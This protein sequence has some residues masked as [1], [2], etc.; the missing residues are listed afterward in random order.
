MSGRLRLARLVPWSIAG[1]AG[2]LVLSGCGLGQLQLTAAADTAARSLA[3]IG[4]T[5]LLTDSSGKVLP[6]TPVVVT[7]SDGRLTRVA[8]SGP[9]GAVV[10]TMATD[11]ASWTSDTTSLSYGS[12]YKISATAVDRTGLATNF[13]KT[14]ATVNPSNF[15]RATV[16]PFDGAIVGVGYPATITLSRSI[17]AANKA[18]ILKHIKVTINGVTGNGAWRWKSNQVIEYR[19]PTYFPGN[20]TISVGINLRG[21]EVGGGAYGLTDSTTTYH[22]GDSMI[23]Y[24]NIKTHQMT[25]T[26]NG[27]TIRVIPVTMGKP[28]FDTRSGVKVILTKEAKRFM[29][30]ATGGTEK[31][32]PNYYAL[33]VLDAMRLTWSG[34]FLHGAPWSVAAQGVA[35]VSHGC[36]GM[37]AA[38]AAWLFSQSRIGDVVV[39]TGSARPMTLDNG[40]GVWNL[41]WAQWQSTSGVGTLG[42]NTGTDGG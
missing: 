33:W 29:D 21:V 37:S 13:T 20:S 23:S 15:V 32:S 34:E 17:D 10:G 28:G 30:A 39:Y 36:T 5:S 4:L 41:T 6:G 35:N 16:V 42:Y 2:A 7:V 25:V 3:H 40:I 11:A 8:I 14:L 9:D 18:K 22:T 27:K 12:T 26:K 1:I 19:T 38:D 24:I 31:N